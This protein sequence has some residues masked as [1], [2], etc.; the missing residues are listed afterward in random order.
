MVK[1][2]DPLG[3]WEKPVL[4]YPAKGIIDTTP[5]WDED[6]K[7]Y[8]VNGWAASRSGLNAILTVS[9]MAP[10]GKSLLEDP[11]LVYDGTYHG[12]FTI[13]G[14]KFYKRNGYYYILASGRRRA[15]RMAGGVTLQ[16]ALRILMK[17]K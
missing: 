6:G 16:I 11:V 9:E 17:T 4:V 3:E 12:D 1:T 13:E 14:P 10:D 5:L 15:H 2:K 7:A 8:L